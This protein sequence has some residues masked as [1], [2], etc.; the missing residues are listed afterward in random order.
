MEGDGDGNPKED[1]GAFDGVDKGT[2]RGN[3]RETAAE[4]QEDDF[5]PPTS[6]TLAKLFDKD[7]IHPVRPFAAD[8]GGSV[9]GALRWK[10]NGWKWGRGLQST[11]HINKG[12][13]QFAL[14]AMKFSE[15]KTIGNHLFQQICQGLI[16]AC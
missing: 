12:V 13:F 6:K 14:N 11:H 3:K 10:V 16:I 8:G 4:P 15:W 2:D 1:G 7:W 9:Q 5:E